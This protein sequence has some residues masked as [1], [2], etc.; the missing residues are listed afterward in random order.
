LHGPRDVANENANGPRERRGFII[1]AALFLS[2]LLVFNLDL[3]VDWTRDYVD[4]VA[5]VERTNGIRRGS[6]VVVEGVD[7]GRVTDIGFVGHGDSAVV[8]VDLRLEARA[9]SLVRAGSDVYT[10][11]RRFIGE[12]VVRI[13][14]GDPRAPAIEDGDTLRGASRPTLE[15]LIDRGS[16]FPAALDSLTRTLAGLQD[17]VADRRPELATLTERL[18]EVTASAG[19]LT[20]RLEGGSVGRMMDDPELASRVAA[21]QDR[22]AALGAAVDTARSRYGEAGLGEPLGSLARRSQR[23]GDRLAAL[24]ERLEHGDGVLGRL[25]RDSALAVAVGGVQAQIDTLMTDALSLAARM[26]L[27]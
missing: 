22:L 26:L 7:A 21:L 16:T 3:V 12:P 6:A 4:V 15:A 9:R 8:A 1:L 13:A 5:L 25:Q 10:A 19:E 14:A 23:L 27:P 17:L 20:R 2:A 24:H 11:K 18:G